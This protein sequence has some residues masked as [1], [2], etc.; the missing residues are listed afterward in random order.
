MNLIN[1]IKA[2]IIE[3]T[4]FGDLA[5]I[6]SEIE[7]SP[8]IIHVL[9]SKPDSSSLVDE[10]VYEVLSRTIGSG[11]V[12]ELENAVR[13][14]LAFKVAGTRIELSDIPPSL[15]KKQA[16]PDPDVEMVNV[17]SSAVDAM[18][19]GGRLTLAEMVEQFEA[20][21]LNEAMSRSTVTHCELAQRLGLSRR[22]FYHKLRKYDLPRPKKP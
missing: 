14:I 9:I 20:M 3:P 16:T 12:R 22:T 2:K 4:P 21:I 13:Q 10:R 18:L 15:L 7:G 19:R 8:R 1:Q 5:L 11:N 6:W 17:L